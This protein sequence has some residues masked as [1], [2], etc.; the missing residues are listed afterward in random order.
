MIN[1]DLSGRGAARTEDDQGTPTQSHLSPSILEYTKIKQS[2]RV[3]V[4]KSEVGKSG[5][6]LKTVGRG[7][8][9]GGE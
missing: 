3:E 8:P 2:W 5:G 7:V 9:A 6:G 4:N 1:S